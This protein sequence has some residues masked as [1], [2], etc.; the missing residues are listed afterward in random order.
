MYIICGL[1]NTTSGTSTSNSPIIQKQVRG[2]RVRDEGVDQSTQ[3]SAIYQ[4]I[5]GL[6]KSTTSQTRPLV[7]VRHTVSSGAL[8]IDL[9]GLS[10]TQILPFII[11]YDFNFKT[12][13]VAYCLIGAYTI[14]L[15][16][17][18]GLRELSKEMLKHKH[19][20]TG[21][22]IFILLILFEGRLLFNSIVIHLFSF[23]FLVIISSINL[24]CKFKT[25]KIIMF[26]FKNQIHFRTFSYLHSFLN[27]CIQNMI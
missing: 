13:W 17:S 23:K 24:T 2:K 19:T 9:V 25:Q 7:S 26:K 22:F 15:H 12:S 27:F 5:Y 21:Y 3:D 18:T 16:L 20:S 10:I 8:Y 11:L 14:F 4:V 6:K 1:I